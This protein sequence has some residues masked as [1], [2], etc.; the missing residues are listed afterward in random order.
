MESEQ[1]SLSLPPSPGRHCANSRVQF[2]RGCL[3]PSPEARDSISFG[4]EDILYTA[5]SDS[6]DF[7]ATSLD[8]LPHSGQEAQSSPAY[9]ELVEV[10][11]RATEKLSLDWPDEPRKYQS[12]KLDEHFLSG[13]GSRPTR[14]KLPFFLACTTRFP[15]QCLI[16]MIHMYCCFCSF[17][18]SELSTENGGLI[19]IHI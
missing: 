9:T 8:V 11:A 13:S 7:G 3:A 14:R 17:L 4:F 5:A 12:S 1:F 10:L 18:L 19:Y 16:G 15:G 2:S 6:E